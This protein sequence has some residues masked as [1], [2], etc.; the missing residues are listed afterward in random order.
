MVGV[1][2]VL[3]T[4]LAGPS[5]M[6]DTYW[7]NTCHLESHSTCSGEVKEGTVVGDLSALMCDDK[8]IKV[9]IKVST[10]CL[11]LPKHPKV[12]WF[13]DNTGLHPRKFNWTFRMAEVEVKT[14]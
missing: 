5:Q 4:S 9:P 12:S 13:G 8:N 3:C 14:S 11:P 6:F 10:E 1:V 7:S 2:Y